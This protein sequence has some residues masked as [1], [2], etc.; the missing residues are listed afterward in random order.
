[1]LGRQRAF[2]RTLSLL[3]VPSDVFLYPPA[4]PVA[5]PVESHDNPKKELAIGFERPDPWHG[6]RAVRLPTP[7]QGSLLAETCGVSQN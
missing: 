6:I 2:R 1:M 5:S 7:D 3:S 4:R